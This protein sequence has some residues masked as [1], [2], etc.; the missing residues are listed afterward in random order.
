MVRVVVFETDKQTERKEKDV[1]RHR[2]RNR[3]SEIEN[4]C[5]IIRKKEKKKES[6]IHRAVRRS[7]KKIKNNI[8]ENRSCPASRPHPVRRG[9]KN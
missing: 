3:D 7:G 4:K 8:P 9:I 2:Y 6:D 1:A 5:M